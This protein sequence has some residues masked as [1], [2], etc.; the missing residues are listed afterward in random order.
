MT[1]QEWTGPA[2]DGYTFAYD[3]NLQLEQAKA[4]AG[5]SSLTTTVRHD[6]DGRVA[7]EGPFR[8]FRS[9]PQ[10]AI[11]EIAGGELETTQT[12]DAWADLPPGPTPSTATRATRWC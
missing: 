11:T 12:W 7:E 1:A 2:A 9:G 6:G 10:G 8:F 4:S 5:A 3:S